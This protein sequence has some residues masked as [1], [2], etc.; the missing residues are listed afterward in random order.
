MGKAN[1]Q[2]FI[3]EDK[4]HVHPSLLLDN[5]LSVSHR[6]VNDDRGCEPVGSW[7]IQGGSAFG[8]GRFDLFMTLESPGKSWKSSGNN[9][10]N[11]EG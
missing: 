11:N 5:N 10:K 1:I 3:F 7:Y 2:Y 8:M 4:P 6:W 9:S